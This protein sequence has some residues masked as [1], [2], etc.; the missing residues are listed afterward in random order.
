[1]WA[2]FNFDALQKWLEECRKPAEK[3]DD[4][5]N[6]KIIKDGETAIPSGNQFS[7]VFN[8]EE[9]WLITEYVSSFG[10]LKILT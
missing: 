5:K 1:M 2:S 9:K 10:F 4:P 6:S 3:A 8:I 7:T